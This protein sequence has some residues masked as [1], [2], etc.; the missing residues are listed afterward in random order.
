MHEPAGPQQR[1]PRLRTRRTPPAKPGDAR[2]QRAAV[3]VDLSTPGTPVESITTL[4]ARVAALARF[5]PADDPELVD[6]RRQLQRLTA[7]ADT[8]RSRIRTLP[9]DAWTLDSVSEAASV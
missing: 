7:N 2:T 9:P 8:L 6:C 3:D 4:H 1:A 5:R